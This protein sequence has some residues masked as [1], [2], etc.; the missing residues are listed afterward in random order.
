MGW[1]F[2]RGKAVDSFAMKNA[3]FLYGIGAAR[4][5]ERRFDI[6]AREGYEQNPIVYACVTK[7]AR[8]SASVDLVVYRRQGG[9]LAKIDNSPLLGLLERPNAMTG[10]RKFRE[11]MATNYLVGG[12]AYV[13]GQ[14]IDWRSR[15]GRPPTE[16]W[17]LPTQAMKVVCQSRSFLPLAYEYRPGQSAPV[18]FPVNQVTGMSEVLL[19]KAVNPMNPHVGLPPLVAAAFGVDTFNAGQ[20]WN[21]ALLDNEARPSGALEFVDGEGKPV[22]LTD[23]QRQDVK[24]MLDDRFSGKGNAGRPLVLE[25]GM[26]W[27]QMSL[28]PKDM[29][30]R[31]T[32]LTTA[33]FIAGVFQTPPQLVNIPGESTY[34]NYGEAKVAYYSDTVLPFLESILEDLNNWLAPLYG[35]DVFI[36]YDEE[37]IPALEPRR[38]EKGDRINAATY[39]TIDEKREAMGLDA[40]PGGIGN[41]VLVPSS[42]LPLE[43][44]GQ[45][46]EVAEPGSEADVAEDDDGEDE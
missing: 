35:D 34:S 18:T 31:E 27:V 3:T 26:K 38:K 40:L 10:G 30:H 21:K 23:E 29:D 7:L 2:R 17:L 46:P 28:S 4:W 42:M 14:G 43:L 41:T 36:W 25:G 19:L 20:A 6:L 11:A 13:Q 22:A 45:M 24:R 5:L 37:A 32:M 44:A 15:S 33:R 8:A 12:N 16:L 9:R 1:P 39:L